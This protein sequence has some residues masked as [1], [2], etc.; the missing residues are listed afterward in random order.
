MLLLYLVFDTIYHVRAGLLDVMLAESAQAVAGTTSR[1]WYSEL[2][3]GGRAAW[4]TLTV[5]SPLCAF[6]AF[7]SGW[8]F[9]WVRW[10]ARWPKGAY[11]SVCVR[12]LMSVW[13]SVDTW[14]GGA[15]AE[16]DHLGRA[17]T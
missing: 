16:D 9:E 11:I 10:D 15:R 13:M 17:S 4:T 6:V 7:R 12:I 3:R 1:V 14:V 2:V 8:C 5:W